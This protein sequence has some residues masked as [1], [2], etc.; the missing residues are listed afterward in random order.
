M[1]KICDDDFDRIPARFQQLDAIRRRWHRPGRL[2]L[3]ARAVL[4]DRFGADW[5]FGDFLEVDRNNDD[6]FGGNIGVFHNHLETSDNGMVDVYGRS[7]FAPTP[8]LL[9]FGLVGWSWLDIDTNF[10][11]RDDEDNLLFHNDDN[12]TANGLTVGAGVEWKFT[13]YPCRSAPSIVSLNSTISTL[14][15]TLVL[16]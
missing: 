2:R 11:V 6:D 14:T 4:R 12:V 1:T 5:T 15:A 9:V 3:P 10:R 13:D 16:A 8:N 7:G